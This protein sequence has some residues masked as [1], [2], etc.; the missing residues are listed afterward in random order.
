MSEFEVLAGDLATRFERGI[1]A[2]W[3]D[4]D[5]V[6]REVFAY[7]YRTNPPYRAFAESRGR[8]PDQVERW[9]DIPA[10]P[11]SAF[12]HLAL[13][14]GDPSRVE[15]VFR[16]SGTTLQGP[17]GR[18]AHH[19]LSLGLYEAAALPN[20]AAHLVPD[21]AGGTRPRLLS[22]VPDDR[23]LP[24]SSLAT[25]MG[26]ARSRLAG[27][28][29]VLASTDGELDMTR[30][31][32]ALSA[33]SGDGVPVWVAGTAFAFVHLLDQA[34]AR[35]WRVELPA[36]SRLMET[37]GFKGR[38]RAVPRP[39]LYAGL[40][41]TLGVP[42]PRMV[43]EYGMTELLSQFYEPVLRTAGAPAALDGRH[44]VGPPW[45]R[46]RVL[47]PETLEPLATGETGLLCH[48]DLANLGS[49]AA[50]LT[51]D[52]GVAVEGGFRVL[53][54]APGAEPRGCSLAL[55]SLLEARR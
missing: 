35:G 32:A 48:L 10:V 2:T 30:T 54:R 37:G 3:P 11:A 28:S 8:S 5:Q 9:Q 34:G 52:V 44:H 26:F 50:V 17:S 49:V 47:D 38:S 19:V 20:L 46:T 55:E 22:L 15:R 14:S 24:E 39:D 13:V 23:E 4:F 40:E 6:A 41:A 33:A 43:N 45:V 16:T 18:G 31:F 42:T 21:A 36:G 7:Q 25:M 1:D 51:A 12:K 29:E 27:G 53:G